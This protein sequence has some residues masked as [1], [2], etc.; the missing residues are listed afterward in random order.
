VFLYP[1]LSCSLLLFWIVELAFASQENP[2]RCFP[3]KVP[4][5][6]SAYYSPSTSKMSGVGTLC[7]RVRLLV[8]RQS[9]SS[10]IG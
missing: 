7:A 9:N 10:A 1:G 8:D 4:V 2:C 5:L 6:H 3:R